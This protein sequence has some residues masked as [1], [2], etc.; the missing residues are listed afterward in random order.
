M[1]DIST[2]RQSLLQ[3]L[4]HL[5]TRLLHLEESQQRILYLQ[6]ENARLRQLLGSK[7]QLPSQ[8]TIAEI[9]GVPLIPSE[10]P[11]S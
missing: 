9:I 7:A 3:Q 8:A 6:A 11:S 10:Q 2:D 5:N 4:E 1:A